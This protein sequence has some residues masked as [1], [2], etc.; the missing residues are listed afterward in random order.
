MPRDI[1]IIPFAS[2]DLTS[3]TTYNQRDYYNKSPNVYP[4][5]Q[6][7]DISK[8]INIWYERPLWGKVDTK[9]RYIMPD[10]DFLKPIGN[11]LQAVNFVA[12]A[13]I[14][15]RDFVLDATAKL[16]TC[17]TS[18]I[19]IDQPQKAFDD[20]ID[21][22]QI[23]FEDFLEPGF[24]N[25]FLSDTDKNNIDNFLDYAKEYSFYA[26]VNNN[27]PHTLA[28]Y[29][30]S[31]QTSYRNSGLV[32]EFSD[33]PYSEDSTKWMKYLSNDFFTDYVRIAA[34]FGFYVSKHFPWAI[35][36]N[37]NSKQMKRYMRLYNILD[38]NENFNVQYLQSEYIS[39]VSFK[40]Y[41]FLAYYSFITFSP[42]VEKIRV[43]NC[44][45][46]N[47]TL[48]SSYNTKRDVISRPIEFDSALQATYTEFLQVY[49][50]MTFLKEYINLRLLEEK[51]IMTEAKND[52]LFSNISR[53]L[54]SQDIFDATLFLS[55]FL[56][57]ERKNDFISLTSKKSSASMTQ[58]NGTTTPM[59]NDSNGS[60]TIMTL[61]PRSASSYF[62]DFEY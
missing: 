55:D 6:N 7:I 31:P 38:A 52:Y 15:F 53:I 34:S 60:T 1:D 14:E 26:E 16:R 9:Q 57:Q 62:V 48:F 61:N 59:R 27:F 29:L 36:A 41:M 40:K 18:M 39:Y 43:E 2:N 13:Y 20:V 23:Y 11:D 51:V 50:E 49:S 42:N 32:I 37:L 54:N 58:N 22:Y 30:S 28:G 46:R 12:D 33:D 10:P 25:V 44:I 4:Y 8:P 21:Q 47:N 19:P 45:R 5:P 35:A 17:M 3:R 56:A 24:I